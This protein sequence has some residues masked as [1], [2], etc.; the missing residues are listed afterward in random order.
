M[1]P[2]SSLNPTS[3]VLGCVM[4]VSGVILFIKRM[5]RSGGNGC[6]YVLLIGVVIAMGYALLSGLSG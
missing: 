4:G 1:L 5:D 2:I 3:L 6:F